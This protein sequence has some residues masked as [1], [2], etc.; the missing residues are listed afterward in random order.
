MLEDKHLLEN[1]G[2]PLGRTI[3]LQFAQQLKQ[4][5]I[6]ILLECN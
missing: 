2:I 6:R 1:L 4:T 3:G 5:S